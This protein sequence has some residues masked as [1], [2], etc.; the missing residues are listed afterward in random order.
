MNA[1]EALVR[2]DELGAVNLVPTLR[3]AFEKGTCPI[4]ETGSTL[5]CNIADRD[6]PRFSIVPRT[7]AEKSVP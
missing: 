4:P 2:M 7:Q 1:A 3:T 6:D 5:V